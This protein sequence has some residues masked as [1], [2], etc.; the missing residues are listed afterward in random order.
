MNPT[1]FWPWWVG[2]LT[3]GSVTV[4]FTILIDRP[5]GVSGSWDRVIHWRR[6][7]LREIQDEQFGDPELLA[8]ALAEAMAGQGS[9]PMATE[10]GPAPVM[11]PEPAPSEPVSLDPMSERAS[12]ERAARVAEPL[13]RP[14]PLVAEAVFL[15][16]MF[17][18]GLLAAKVS[19][20]FELRGDMGPD[21]ARL[22][23][24]NPVLMYGA[25]LGGGVLVGFGT[26]LGGGCSSGH[27]LSGCSRLHPAS[28]V[29]TAVFFGSAAVMSTL[30]WKVI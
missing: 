28:L 4:L 5:L 20:R 6:E 16:A 23:T 21:F 1:P 18:G 13:R 8:A 27:G 17:L 25:L 11:P 15:V 30:L 7:R 14:V 10:V 29:A 26:R 9:P 24:A 12:S 3:L 19:G 2:A 22:V